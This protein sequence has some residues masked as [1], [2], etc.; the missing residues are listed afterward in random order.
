MD[1]WNCDV[2]IDRQASFKVITP[3]G[4]AEV[5]KECFGLLD[6]PTVEKKEINLAP[7]PIFPRKKS[8]DKPSAQEDKELKDIVNKNYSLKRAISRPDDLI[9][10]FHWIIMRVRR[11]KKLTQSQFAREIKEPEVVVKK[12][13]QGYLPENYS[14]LIKKIENYL[15]VNLSRENKPHSF[16]DSVEKVKENLVKASETGNVQF[17]EEITK[18]LTLN[19]LQEMKKEK[20]R[21]VFN[22]EVKEKELPQTNETQNED[23]PKKRKRFSWG[24][25]KEKYQDREIPK[26]NNRLNSNLVERKENIGNIQEKSALDSNVS[27]NINSRER[28]QNR[29]M[30]NQKRMPP[31]N[32]NERERL[33]EKRFESIEKKLHP[34]KDLS[35]EEI[36]DLL[37]GRKDN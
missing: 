18:T 22:S 3:Q 7:K 20:E 1:C 31:K 27:R 32:I 30:Q 13:E 26:E 6:Y 8:E 4:I 16:E 14:P 24:R 23:I 10:N 37:F 36:N 21:E 33:S 12:L 34:R 28:F 11:T 25:K 29:E 5:C 17:D 35:D 19:D 15:R 2:N 9:E